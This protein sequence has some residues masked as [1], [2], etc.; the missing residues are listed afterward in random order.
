MASTQIK[1]IDYA[2]AASL[3]DRKKSVS[4]LSKKKE[5]TGILCS[6]K[7]SE[8]KAHKH[9]VTQRYCALCK[10][11][12][13]PERKYMLHSAKDCTGMHTIKDGMEGYVR[14]RADTVKQHK[15]SGNKWKKY[16]KDLR[17]KKICSIAF[18][19]NP[20]RAVKSGRSGQKLLRRVANIVTIIPVTSMNPIPC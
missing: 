11:S 3:S 12:G 2:R 17:N 14:S 5:M 15:I 16:L 8:K 20:A 13:I 10:K 1:K 9:H 6:K 19:R 7:G 4:I 18:P